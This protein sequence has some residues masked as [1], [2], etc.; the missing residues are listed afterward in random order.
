MRNQDI[1]LPSLIFVGHFA[2]DNII[3]ATKLHKPTLGGSVSYCSLALRIYTKNVKISIISHIGTLN[4]KESHLNIIKKKDIDFKGIIFSNT[5]NTNFLLDYS[6]RERILTLKSRSPNLEFED[7]PI[8][9][10]KNP[11]DLVVLVPICNETSLQYVSQIATNFPNAYI[12]IDLQGFVR[13]IDEYGNVSIAH[14]D[15]IMLTLTKLI[16]TVG[17]KLILKGSEEEVMMLANEHR[18]VLMTM[19]NFKEYDTNGIFIMTRG[20]NGSVIYKKGY[21][22]LE[23]PAFKSKK[24]VDETGAGDV[25]FSIFLFEFLQSDKSWKSIESA[26]Y[27]A[28]AAASFLI[29]KK[30]LSGCESKKKVLNRVKRR[31]YIKEK[32]GF[33][34]I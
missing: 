7:I 16:D 31:N 3:T 30:G 21:Q 5:K 8:E 2:I 28:S 26:A 13:K 1:Q 6:N 9:F 10:L 18:D 4:L 22:I 14:N 20:E 27:K 11:P 29:E 24:I 15:D 19:E 17:D 12:G 32:G 25:F 34:Y 23:I 33:E